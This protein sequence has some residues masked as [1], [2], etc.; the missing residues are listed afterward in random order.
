[1]NTKNVS[2]QTPSINARSDRD[3]EGV[4][5]VRTIG[6][7]VYRWV[8]NADASNAITFGQAAVAKASDGV[9]MFK[10]VYQTITASLAWIAG[11]VMATDGLDANTGTLPKIFGWIQVYGA[12]ESVSVSGATT[13]GTDLTTGEYLKGV[14]AAGHLVRDGTTPTYRRTLIA[15]TNVGTTTTPAAAYI[16]AY[17]NCI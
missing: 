1:M 6:D 9:N 14:N 4:G 7:R 17:I 2:W 8:K 15:L 11:I 13:G 12:Q 3:L 16:P 10:Y 5:S